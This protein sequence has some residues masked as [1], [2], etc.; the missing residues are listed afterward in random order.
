[1]RVSIVGAGVTGLSVAFQLVERGIGP[2]TIFERN[3]VG[4]GAS[5]IQP[6]GVRQQWGT[7]ANC[8]MARESFAFYRDFPARLETV[9]QA[10]L[11]QCGYLFVADEESTLRTL[12]AG[13]AVQHELGIPSRIVRPDEAAALVPGLAADALLGASYCGEDGYFDRPQ[14]VVEAFAEAAVA[15]GARLVPEEVR[16]VARDG[17]G[18]SLDTA[19]GAHRRGR[20]RRRGRL[21]HAGSARSARLRAADR[22]GAAL[23]L[24]QRAVAGAAAGAARDRRRP[25]HRGEAARR[26]TRPRQR[27]ARLGRRRDAAGRVAPPTARAGGPAAADARVRLAADRGGGLLR[28][29]AGRA[30]DRGRA[31]RTGSGSRRD[32]AATASWSRPA[33]AGSSPT[34][35]AEARCRSGATPCGPTASPAARSLAEAQVI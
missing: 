31:R 29:D 15:R 21:R 22:E 18:W 9:A 35:S 30:A 33:R 16:A 23:P 2:V 32:S 4:S 13:A 28:H 25:R 11:E 3:G 20:R 27:P 5:G 12:E 19:A 17:A 34:R 6:G 26:R 7:R 1:M 24:L 10:R 8:L 14:A